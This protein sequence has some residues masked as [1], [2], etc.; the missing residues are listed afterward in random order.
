MGIGATSPCDLLSLGPGHMC[1]TSLWWWSECCCARPPAGPDASGNTQFTVGAQV[2]RSWGGPQLSV[3]SPLSPRS[4]QE[5]FLHGGYLQRVAGLCPRGL[6]ACSQMHP[7]GLQR[8]HI[9]SRSVTATLGTGVCGS[10]GASSGAAGMAAPAAA[11]PPLVLG[12]TS[13]TWAPCQADT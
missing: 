9:A 3:Q 12:P 8:L 11:E 4:S 10:H 1:A 2:A 6:K 7:R 5:L 13:N